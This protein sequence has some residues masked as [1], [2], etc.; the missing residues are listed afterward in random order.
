MPKKLLESQ[1]KEIIDNFVNGLSIEELAEKFNYSKITITKYLKKGVNEEKF[2]SLLKNNKKR[3]EKNL[4]KIIS[5]VKNS[6][7]QEKSKNK[8]NSNNQKNLSTKTSREDKH[9]DSFEQS[10]FVEITPLN[11]AIDNELRK[12]LSS[13]S[14]SDIDLP[15]IVFMIVNSKVELITKPLLDYSDWQF[16]SEN[17]LSR[18]TIE[19]FFDIK[20]AKSLCNKEQKVIKVPNPKVF[21]VVAPLLVSKG[22]TRIVSPHNL[23]AL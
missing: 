17:E 5:S 15:E 4:S 1:K 10:S 11:F 8:K 6:N 14:I 7:T 2:K 19:I 20:I 3:L 13:I 16:L 22:I 12:D 18:L 21:K 9:L 23:I